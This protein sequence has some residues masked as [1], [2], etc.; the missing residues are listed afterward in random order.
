MSTEALNKLHI[1]GYDLLSVNHG[2]WTVSS[3]T[4]QLGSFATR[5]E[6]IAYVTALPPKR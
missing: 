5:E 1:N 3:K 4:H 2:P 6:A